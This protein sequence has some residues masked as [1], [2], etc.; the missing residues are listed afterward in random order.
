MESVEINAVSTFIPSG[1][2]EVSLLAVPF[3]LDQ[4]EEVEAPLHFNLV[5]R[6]SLALPYTSI[7]LSTR[8]FLQEFQLEFDCRHSLLIINYKSK[9]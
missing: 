5:Y 3:K 6:L 8:T 2:I 7:P 4:V 9:S 1:F